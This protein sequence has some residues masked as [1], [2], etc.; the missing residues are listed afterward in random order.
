MDKMILGLIAE[1]VEAFPRISGIVLGIA[2]HP[3]FS[4]ILTGR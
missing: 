3:I 2:M 4:F 1:T